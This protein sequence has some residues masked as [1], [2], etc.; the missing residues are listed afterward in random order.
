MEHWIHM[1]Y[2]RCSTSAARGGLFLFLGVS[3]ALYTDQICTALQRVINTLHC[4]FSENVNLSLSLN[5]PC[6]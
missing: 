4:T 1:P 5:V 3:A 2:L 6:G